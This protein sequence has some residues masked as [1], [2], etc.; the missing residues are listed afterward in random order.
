MISELNQALPLASIRVLDVSRV[1]A[2]PWCGM[3]PHDFGGRKS[4]RRPLVLL[5]KLTGPP[6]SAIA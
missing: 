1:L 3:V 6:P 5:N 4:C 2:G